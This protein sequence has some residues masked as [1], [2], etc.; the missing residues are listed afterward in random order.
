MTLDDPA[1]LPEP[2][3]PQD[4]SIAKDNDE[5]DRLASFRLTYRERAAT[6]LLYASTCGGCAAAWTIPL[7][8]FLA[9]LGVD[10]LE[11]LRTAIVREQDRR[12]GSTPPSAP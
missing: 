7:S 8:E 1:E 11:S 10:S 9:V 5:D 12:C 3:D 6:L 4:N 2:W